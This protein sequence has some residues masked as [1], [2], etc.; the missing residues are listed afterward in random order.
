[1]GVTNNF[2][3]KLFFVFGRHIWNVIGVSGFVALLA[4]GILFVESFSTTNLKS[5]KQYFGRSYATTLKS[6]K[7]YHGKK[8]VD[9]NQALLDA[10][11][12]LEKSGK[13]LDYSNWIKE[14]KNKEDGY[15]G[16][17]NFSMSKES[18]VNSEI[19]FV[20]QH[21]NYRKRKYL[22][23]Q[24]KIYNQNLPNKLIRKIENQEKSYKNYKNE[25][26]VKQN[27]QRQEYQDYKNKV[28][29]NN[30]LKLIRRT[31]S[32]LPIG[33]GFGVLS[34]SSVISTI[35]SIERNTRK[36]DPE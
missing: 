10:R 6:K 24:K 13:I 11:I 3:R 2:E 14:M 20:K 27:N 33:W 16:Y 5:K 28:T 35:F 1:M 31:T 17:W 34:V 18:D 36:T 15:M 23:Y 21:E 29:Q 32:L 12:E 22:E 26:L 4:G 30:S 25:F 7:D 8:Y 9:S 19:D